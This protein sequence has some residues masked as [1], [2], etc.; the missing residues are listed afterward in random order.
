MTSQESFEDFFK[1]DKNPDRSLPPGRQ[2]IAVG[3][4]GITFAL[5]GAA[6]PEGILSNRESREEFAEK[7]SS[8][9]HSDEF[10]SELSEEIGVP[11]DSE[12][13]DQFVAR[14]KKAMADLLRKK[15]E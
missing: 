4:T 13:E 8:L 7:V 14:A 2:S 9:S 10:I 3:A 12:T 5:A 1:S 15:L 11:M 6:L